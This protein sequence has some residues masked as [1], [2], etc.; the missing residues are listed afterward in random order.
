VD[1][2]KWASPRKGKRL[3]VDAKGDKVGADTNGG[4]HKCVILLSIRLNAVQTNG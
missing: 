2:V 4:K 3:M 1:W